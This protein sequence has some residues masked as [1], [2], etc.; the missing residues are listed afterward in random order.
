MVGFCGSR[1]LPARF[2][3][4][5]AAVVSAVAEGGPVAV[6]CA[7]GADAL[8]RAACP[9]A[10]VFRASAFGSGRGAFA[11]RSAALVRAVVASPSPLLVGFVASASPAGV[12]PSSSWRSGRPP[13]GSWSSLALG[14]GL[15]CAVSLVWCASGPARLPVWAGGAWAAG[16]LGQVACW[17]WVPAALQPSLF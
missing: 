1:S 16:S 7:A 6:G 15:G 4:Q 5:V 9:S 14:I 8:V 13:S 10:A 12:V 17:S 11:A 3:G 2:A